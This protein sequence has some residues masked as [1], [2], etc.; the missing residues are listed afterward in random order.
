MKKNRAFRF[1]QNTTVTEQTE[2][3]YL[4]WHND[5]KDSI[6]SLVSKDLGDTFFK[7]CSYRRI[8]DEV[9]EYPVDVEVIR[10]EPEDGWWIVKHADCKEVNVARLKKGTR[11]YDLDSDCGFIQMDK[12]QDYTF[13]RKIEEP[14]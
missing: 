7:S 9:F 10:P 8:E 11:L 2:G 14:S 12:W 3:I 13:I 1:E 6:P 4:S 5:R